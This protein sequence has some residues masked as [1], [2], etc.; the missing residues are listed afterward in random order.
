MS[1]DLFQAICIDFKIPPT[2][3][4]V[5]FSSFIVSQFRTI[6]L[7]ANYF[8]ASDYIDDFIHKYCSITVSTLYESHFKSLGWMISL[9]PSAKRAMGQL[10]H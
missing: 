10:L 1:L 8:F 9:V 6:S 7:I 2:F 5:Y 4:D 3:L